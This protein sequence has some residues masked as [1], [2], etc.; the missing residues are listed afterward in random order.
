ML[1]QKVIPIFPLPL[2][3]CPQE[4]LPL[5]IF[6][7]RYKRLIADCR[8]KAQN[9]EYADFGINFFNE[10]TLCPVGATVHI[11]DIIEEYTDGRMDILTIGRQRYRIL[12]TRAHINAAA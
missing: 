11:E 2:V 6:E 9:K 12:E 3:V 5:H 10:T 8:D 7:D 4:R 1:P